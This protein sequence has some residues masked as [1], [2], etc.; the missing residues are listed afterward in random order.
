MLISGLD[1]AHLKE[2]C[3]GHWIGAQGDDRGLKGEMG[4]DEQVLCSQD[5]RLQNSHLH[6]AV[7]ELELPKNQMP[8]VQL[9]PRFL[10]QAMACYRCSHRRVP[11]IKH[12]ASCYATGVNALLTATD[13]VIFHPHSPKVDGYKNLI[14]GDGEYHDFSMKCLILKRHTFTDKLF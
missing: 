6:T 9:S 11:I 4:E 14:V 12:L 10:S 5:G 7:Q 13:S 1:K 2:D 8:V 3:G